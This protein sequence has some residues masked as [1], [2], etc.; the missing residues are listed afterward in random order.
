M[1]NMVAWSPVRTFRT[2][3]QPPTLLD[4]E[5]WIIDHQPHADLQL[6][7]C[8]RSQQ[9]HSAGFE[10]QH[11]LLIDPESDGDLSLIHAFNHSAGGDAVL[12]GASERPEWTKL[13]V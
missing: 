1:V 12:A 13:V 6:V 4:P 9:L 5:R 2:A 10:Q 7:G 8:G 11:I 3:I